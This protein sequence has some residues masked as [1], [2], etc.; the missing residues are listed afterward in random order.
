ME[1]IKFVL[2]KTVGN[3][4]DV[5]YWPIFCYIVEKFR[6]YKRLNYLHET[7]KPGIG[8]N[9]KDSQGDLIMAFSISVNCNNI[10]V[11]WLSLW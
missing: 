8:G 2:A 3:L 5:N 9:V 4:R 10:I 11:T 1:N 6:P 7:G